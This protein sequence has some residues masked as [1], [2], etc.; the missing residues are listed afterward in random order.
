[1]RTSRPN[2]G[3][4]RRK[5]GTGRHLLAGGEPRQRLA[6]WLRLRW[7]P[8][9]PPTRWAFDSDLG[10]EDVGARRDAHLADHE[11]IVGNDADFTV[12][13]STE[14]ASHVLVLGIVDVIGDGRTVRPGRGAMAIICASQRAGQPRHRSRSGAAAGHSKRGKRICA[15]ANGAQIH[16]TERRCPSGRGPHGRA[17]RWP[18][19]RVRDRAM[20]KGRDV[21]SVPLRVKA[22]SSNRIEESG[23][24]SGRR[25]AVNGADVACLPSCCEPPLDCRRPAGPG[26]VDRCCHGRQQ[27]N[28]AGQR[29]GAGPG[30]RPRRARRARSGARSHGS[31]VD[32]RVNRSPSAR[33]RRSRIS[34]GLRPGVGRRPQR[35][36]Q[37]RGGDGYPAAADSGG[38]PESCGS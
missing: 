11:I 5:P 30:G 24:R 16:A 9:R 37:Q 26:R 36:D 38:C 22:T 33:P 35:P 8:A 20:S 4:P 14:R 31:G 21:G 27:R 10:V 18:S 1:M 17:R 25:A 34:A 2:N 15:H 12:V 28:R 29:T 3:P 19:R 7:P 23:W 6:P 13:T 32:H